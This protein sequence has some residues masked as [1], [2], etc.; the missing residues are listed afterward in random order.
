MTTLVG[1]LNYL[2][3]KGPKMFVWEN[4]DAFLDGASEGGGQNIEVLTQHFRELRYYSVPF[5]TCVSEHGL[6][7]QR[8][9]LFVLGVAK[10]WPVHEIRQ[11]AD[12][13]A[14]VHRFQK[15]FFAT[16]VP[17]LD[18]E[19]C[20]LPA[21]SEYLQSELERRLDE[22]AKKANKEGDKTPAWPESHKAYCRTELGKRDATIQVPEEADGTL[23]TPFL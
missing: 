2:R 15:V 22:K 5:K 6:P 23:T 19:E 17:A 4:V 14:F 20:L 11:E 18:L 7:Q 21:D 3:S 16:K 12:W 10:D 8:K 13:D 1:F 9:R